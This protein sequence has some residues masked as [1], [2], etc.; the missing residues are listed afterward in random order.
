MQ[1]KG[2]SLDNPAYLAAANVIAATTNLPLDRVVKKSNN[3]V[4][5]TNSDLET[6]ERLVLLGGWARLGRL[7]LIKRQKQ[8]NLSLENLN[9]NQELKNVKQ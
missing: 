6:W 7:V 1:E 8:I 2:W 4:N 9:K 5:A 3:V